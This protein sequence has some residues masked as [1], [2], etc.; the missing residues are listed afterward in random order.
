MK[1]MLNLCVA[2]LAAY[3]M[4]SCTEKKDFEVLNGEWN[5]VSVGEMSIPDSV[6]VFM[7]FNAAEQLVYGNTGCNYLTGVLPSKVD[8]STPLFATIGSTRKWCNDMAIEDAMIPALMD[9]VDFKV[10]EDTLWL[11]N[12]EGTATLTLVK[13]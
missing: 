13:R 3:V 4:V 9:V 7:G 8:P 5:V 12:A 11:L 10:E 1:R 6:D 2:L